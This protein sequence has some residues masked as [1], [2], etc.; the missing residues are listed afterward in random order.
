MQTFDNPTL[1]ECAK[2]RLAA[3]AQ[4][5]SNGLGALRRF[6]AS[7]HAHSVLETQGGRVATKVQGARWVNL[8]L[9][10]LKRALDGV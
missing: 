1:T 10:N 5:F 8:V 9:C 2:P 7:G 6:A 4:A 3:E